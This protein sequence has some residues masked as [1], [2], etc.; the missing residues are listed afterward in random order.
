MQLEQ[1]QNMVGTKKDLLHKI[2]SSM[3]ET[4]VVVN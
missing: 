4:T 1:K 3:T 2:S